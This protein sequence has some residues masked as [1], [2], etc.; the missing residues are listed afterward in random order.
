MLFDVHVYYV[1][2]DI[3]FGDIPVAM[4]NRVVIWYFLYASS[5]CVATSCTVKEIS[6]HNVCQR[7][8]TLRIYFIYHRDY[9]YG[10]YINT[11]RLYTEK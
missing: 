8:Q 7:C 4:K 9:C 1:Q 11:L 2:T 10:Y 6:A 5:A 3:L